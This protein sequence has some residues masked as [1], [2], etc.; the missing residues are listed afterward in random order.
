MSRNALGAEFTKEMRRTHTIYMPDMLHYHN[1]FLEAAFSYGG[2]RLA[3]LPE[4]KNVNEKVLR[5]ISGDY[6]FPTISIISQILAFLQDPQNETEQIAFLEPQA[7]GMC[8]A[9]N[10]Y[11]LIIKTL[12]KS[13]RGEIPVISLNMTGQEKHS[14]FS[15]NR[16]MLVACIAGV[17]YGDLLMLLTQQ[18]K[19]YEQKPGMAEELRKMWTKKL[20]DEISVGRAISGKERRRY[21]Q[22][23][24]TDYKK[25]PTENKAC[26]KV[27]IVGEIYMKYSPIGNQHLEKYLTECGCDYRLGGF[28]NYAIYVVFTEMQNAKLRGDHP[29]IIKVYEFVWN[30]L[31]RIQHELT[32]VLSQAGMICDVEFATLRR[33]ANQVISDQY[34]IG[35]GWLMAGEILA[36]IEQG[37]DRIMILHPF[38]CLVSH[39]GARGI[40]KRIRMLYPQVRIQAIEYDYDQ[41]KAMRESRIQLVLG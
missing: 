36:L 33:L 23:I 26:K 28:V 7:G 15:I 21:F 12:D 17:C 8:R 10:I 25:I 41:S 11:N 29:A 30:Y 40:L 4:Y 31:C 35:D 18:I 32:A 9:G 6:C 39:V 22:Q 3:T 13:G 16:R 1:A 19:P 5:Y 37:Y 24:V 27:G 20:T 14:G 2:Y 38:G 34:N